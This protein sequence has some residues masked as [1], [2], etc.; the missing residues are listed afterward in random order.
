MTVTMKDIAKKTGL[1][2]ATVSRVIN[3]TGYVKEET[4]E[5]IMKTIKELNYTP[6]AVARSLCKKETNIIGVVIPD[7]NNPFFGEV[8]KGISSVADEENLNIILCDTDEKI[9][10]E[11]KSLELLKE[12]RI[13]GIIITPTSD[14]NKFSSEYLCILESLGIPIVLIDRDVKHSNFDGVFLNSIKGACE[15]T[16]ALI[17]AGHKKIAIIGGPSTSKPGRD[18]LRGYK[19]ALMMNG[20]DINEDY[21]F[22]GDFK[23]ES[24]YKIAKQI[25]E[26]KDRPT[27]IFVCNNM[28]NLGC[29]KALNE[30]G[31]RIPDDM[32]L[33]GFDEVEMLDIFG[34]K[35]SVISRPTTEM[36][37]VAMEILRDKLNNNDDSQIKRIILTP[38][39]ILKG[40]EKLVK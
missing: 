32:A 16:E 13:K 23:L 35:I 17:K 22:Y 8:I 31:V 12:Q 39:L 25:L 21:I 29:I 2:I 15:G 18:R 40:S 19:K 6:S 14:K 24:G 10:K 30:K 36:G 37:R 1:S 11:L 38:K 33:I 27:A 3:K 20:I 26:M 9:E 7:I 4:R 5:I 34:V 28:M